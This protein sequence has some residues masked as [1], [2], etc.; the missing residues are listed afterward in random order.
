MLINNLIKLFHRFD[1]K[2]LDSV[3]TQMDQ[4]ASGL[5]SMTVRTRI[6]REKLESPTPITCAFYLHGTNY[7]KRRETIF[8]GK[9]KIILSKMLI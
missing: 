1:T 8:Y 7:T 9:K 5:Y 2:I 3:L 6:P 4:N